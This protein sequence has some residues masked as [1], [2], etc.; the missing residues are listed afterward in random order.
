MNVLSSSA[1]RNCTSCQM[2]AAVCA[3]NAIT[4]ELDADG[5]YRPVVNEEYCIDC[6]LCTKICYR[7]DEDIIPFKKVQLA[8]TNLYGAYAKS[9]EIVESTTSGGVA[10]I[11]AHALLA[12]GYKCVGVVYNPENDCAEDKIVE[13]E[14]GLACF[15]GSKYIQSYTY[16][17]FQ[18]LVHR[19]K[20]E[21]F[22]VFGT[23]CHIYAV[24]KMARQ[25]NVRGNLVLIDLFCHGCPSM[26]VWKKYVK[27]IKKKSGAD[28][29]QNAN[30]RS[31]IKGWGRF[32]VAAYNKEE[33]IFYSS[34][35]HNEFFELF[36]SDLV[37]NEACNDCKLR[38]TLAY[39]DIRLGDFWGKEY[40]LNQ[41]GVSAVSVVSDRAKLLFEKIKNELV[42]KEHKYENF[43]PWQSWGKNHYP[44]MD[45]RLHVL[46]QLRDP[47]ISLKESVEYIYSRQSSK[48]KIVRCAKN[49]IMMLPGNAESWVR[50]LFYKIS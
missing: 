20:D 48:Q 16:D 28:K 15:R 31:K 21:K 43:L 37:L 27:G 49:M 24:D 14:G 9:K 10:D 35:A 30:F 6:G 8:N 34:P 33:P 39:T 7:F 41:K 2:C 3:K 4:I 23:P 18:E 11:L 36:F 45:V 25:K 44:N 47:S 26:N 40:V 38:S 5:F 17:A 22:A 12:E 1:K 32:C 19:C 46:Q 50:W 13:K 42:W 29:L